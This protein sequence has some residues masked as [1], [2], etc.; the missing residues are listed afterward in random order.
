MTTLDWGSEDIT[1]SIDELQ[2]NEDKLG[3]IGVLATATVDAIRE[4]SEAEE[5]VRLAKEELRK[6]Q[7][8]ALPS[9][10]AEIGLSELRL[11]NG[12]KISVST[13]YSASIPKE[14]QEV[15]FNWLYDN[16]HGDI[17]KHN[18]SVDFKKGEEEAAQEAVS[19]LQNIGLI[20]RDEIKVAPMTLKAFVREEL[21]AGRELPEELNVFVTQRA[22]IKR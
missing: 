13:Y 7:D 19:S 15:V 8:E 1:K 3:Q 18:V 2:D 12:A 10:M 22:T 4:V 21:E 11:Q 14:N 16:G 5:K 17:I 9:A 6:L 20:P